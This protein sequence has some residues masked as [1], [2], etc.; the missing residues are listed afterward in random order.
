MCLRCSSELFPFQYCDLPSHKIP[1]DEGEVF[2]FSS[3]LSSYFSSEDPIDSELLSNQNCKYYETTEFK[4]LISSD[5]F[6][7]FLHLNI[8]S[9]SKHFDNFYTFLESLKA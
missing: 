2:R 7:S 6:F 9:I 8:S 5:N 3:N 4:S 1:D